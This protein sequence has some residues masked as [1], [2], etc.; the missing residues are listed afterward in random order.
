MENMNIA[1]NLYIARLSD[2]NNM[3]ISSM[4]GNLDIQTLYPRKGPE[5]KP[6]QIEQSLFFSIENGNRAFR[7]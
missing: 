7:Y 1:F 4:K 2:M 6:T 3:N 5:Y